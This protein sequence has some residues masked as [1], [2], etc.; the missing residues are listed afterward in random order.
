[1]SHRTNPRFSRRALLKLSGAAVAGVLGACRGRSPSSNFKVLLQ[2]DLLVGHRLFENPPNWNGAPVETR[3]LLIVGGG[4]AGLTA[5]YCLRARQPLL[6]ELSASLGGSSSYGESNGLVFAQG[7]HYELE[8]PRYYGPEVLALLEKLGLIIF[9]GT[10]G[11]WTFTDQRFLIPA[12]RS[13]RSWVHGRIRADMLPESAETTRFERLLESFEG[14]LPL[15]L[16]LIEPRLAGMNDISFADYLRDKGLPLTAAFRE[17]LDYHMKDDY[18]AGAGQVSALAG[19]HYYRCRPYYH[20][21]VGIFSPPR[22]NGY[23]VDRLA[24]ALAPGTVRTGHLVSAIRAQDK[25]FTVDVWDG[26]A[27]APLRFRVKQVVY[28]GHK[29]ALRYTFP[30]DAALFAANTYAPWVVMSFLLDNPSLDSVWWQNEVLS[31]DA[32]FLGFVNSMAQT[33]SGSDPNSAVLTAYYCLPERERRLLLQ[34]K[35]FWKTWVGATLELIERVTGQSLAAHVREV[36]V[37]L[38]GHGMPIP[39]PGYLLRDANQLRTRASLVYAGVDNGRLP[40]LYEAFD[41]GI[42]AAGLLSG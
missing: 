24:R 20:Q 31:Q 14:R 22:G 30:A 38:H 11:M 37:K 6:C 26:L 41:S 18:G 16:R 36:R 8:Y 29:H 2:D 15:P 23:F 21:H 12:E 42:R 5:A 7:A 3:D 1:M 17:A 13:G 28:A 25:G 32:R 33:Q 19:V 35:D 40:L 34:P 39:A 4:I 27:Q 10:R 9:D